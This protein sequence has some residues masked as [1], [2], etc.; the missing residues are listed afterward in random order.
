VPQL[1]CGHVGVGLVGEEQL[2]AVPV[3][4][5][6][7][8]LGARV[9]ILTPADRLGARWPAR[10]VQGRE[11]G[12]LGAKPV[13]QLG[14]QRRPGMADHTGAVGGDFEARTRPGSLHPQRALL[15]R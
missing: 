2:E 1:Q 13:G 6:E 9:G 8:E 10:K 5:G 15:E 11:L 14:Q 3:G 7:A 12:D 4:V